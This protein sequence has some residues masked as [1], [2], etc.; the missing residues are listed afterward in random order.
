M[1]NKEKVLD[2][3]LMG[4]GGTGMGAFAG[5]LKKSGHRVRG[6]DNA[7]YSPM[8]EKLAE[9]DIHYKTPYQK[10]NLSPPPDLVIVGN[11]IRK[12]NPEAEDMRAR[13][14]A[15]ESFPSALHKLFL[16]TATS[17]V[18]SG[19][20]GKT[21]SSALMAHSLYAAGHDPGFLV[22]GIPLNF[23][24]SYRA[25]GKTHYPFVIEGDE[26][27]TAYFDKRP[28]FI[29]YD[30]TYL[31]IT[32][33]EYDHADIYPNLDSIIDAFSS[34]L[35]TLTKDRTIVYN[36]SDT[37]IPIAFQRSNTKAKL[38][39]YGPGADYEAVDVTFSETGIIFAVKH[40]KSRSEPLSIPLF[41]KHNL[42]NA[43]G[44]YAML[45]E[46]GLEHNSIANAFKTF[47]GVKR[48]MEEIYERQGVIAIDDFAH[49]P[50]AVR[51]TIWAVQQKYP[52]KK[53]WAIFEPR[54][55]TS[56]TKIF[57]RDYQEAFLGCDRA[58]FAPVGR[59]LPADQK[60]DTA[61]IAHV[62]NQR[63]CDAKACMNY[64]E[65]NKEISLAAQDIVL[66]FMSNGDFGGI[67]KKLDQIL[68]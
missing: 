33:I 14:L 63:G 64:D 50:S 67:L 25:S 5:L 21:T 65:L 66:L 68:T 19:T 39:S 62:L 12:D 20:H 27:D 34:L 47:K 37:N 24:E 10:E 55:A 15:Y 61:H 22:G 45:K 36:G 40:H 4:I 17:L 13:D 23:S 26:Y 18:A 3:Y 1:Q 53:L 41:G 42:H 28:K 51:E 52:T 2:I 38:V 8:K 35:K 32:A 7:V 46:Y 54:S 49:H 16:A 58:L 44:C 11:V 59:N 29:H 48:R 9:W 43:L 60:I 31:L 6:S 56:C 30:P 57:E